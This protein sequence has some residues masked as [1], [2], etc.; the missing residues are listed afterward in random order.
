[1]CLP[2]FGNK[3]EKFWKLHSKFKNLS[4]ITCTTA[5][6]K[7]Q[8]D[9][10]KTHKKQIVSLQDSRSNLTKYSLYLNT[11][12]IFGLLQWNFPLQRWNLT[13]TNY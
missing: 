9:W 6:Q 5:Q 2:V 13:I 12:K 4:S 1:L 8:T 3:Y 7:W 10:E 11:T